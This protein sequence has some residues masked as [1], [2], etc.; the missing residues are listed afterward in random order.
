MY[1]EGGEKKKKDKDE[2]MPPYRL[3][4]DWL[5]VLFSDYET[6]E[7]LQESDKNIGWND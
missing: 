5:F 6:M 4:T 7:R 2:S 3:V 1:H